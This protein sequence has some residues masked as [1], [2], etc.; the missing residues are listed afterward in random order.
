MKSSEIG[1]R[2]LFRIAIL[3][4]AALAY[5]VFVT[6]SFTNVT[7]DEREKAETAIRS[8]VNYLCLQLEYLGERVDAFEQIEDSS[9]LTAEVLESQ[10]PEGFRFL[11]DPVGEILSGYSLAETGTVAIIADDTVIASDDARMPVGGNVR[12]LLGD[13]VCEAIDTSLSSSELQTVPYGGVFDEPSDVSTYSDGNDDEAFLFAAQQDA[14]TV[15]II[16]P[17]SMAFRDRNAILG[18]ETS[19]VLVMLIAVG[20][21]MDRLLCFLVAQRIDKTNEAL[22][23]ITSGGLDARVE[24][25]GTREF[26]SLASGINDTV[27][28]LQGWITEAESRMDSELSAARAIQESALPR[29]FPPFPDIPKFDVYA[30]MDAAREVGGDFYDFF[31]VGDGGPDSGKLAFLVADVSG[32]GIPAALLMMKAKA[33]VRSELEDGLGLSQAVESVNAAL[34]DGNDACM[35]VTMWV[36]VL[37]YGTGQVEYVN[38][39]HNPPLLWQE[40]AGWR[41]LRSLSGLPLGL[42]DGCS[43][44]VFSLD[45]RNG[46]KFLLYT[47]GV[48]EAKNVDGELYGEERLKAAANACGEEHPEAF[49]G[50]VHNDVVSFAQGAKQFDDITILALEINEL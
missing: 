13:E 22:G 23:C 37:D 10:N 46:D 41:W 11:T 34:T 32:K 12:E 25:K 5:L 27:E 43:Y 20:A 44:E 9:G 4:V 45:C 38:A 47:D 42:L 7:A 26:R 49:V 28:A 17:K 15:M 1:I 39:G 21:I 2:G 16:E 3:I 36:G 29:T 30:T 8:E 33:L 18:R 24:G 14:Y 6:I 40:G 50:S 48:T 35:F 19:A 31:R